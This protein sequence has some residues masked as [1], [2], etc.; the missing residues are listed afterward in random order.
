LSNATIFISYRRDD[1]SG[2]A[3]RLYDRLSARFGA[4]RIFMDIDTIKPGVDFVTVIDDAVAS[5]AVLIALIGKQWLT[6]TDATGARRLDNPHDFNRLEIESG[7]KRSTTVIPVLVEGA[8]MPSTEDLPSTMAALAR[9]NAIELSDVRWDYDVQR[10]ITTI[11]EVV[12]EPAPPPAGP[13]RKKPP[14]L[15]LA[16][17]ALVLVVAVVAAF[18]LTQGGSPACGGEGAGTASLANSQ[19]AFLSDRDGNVEIYGMRADGTRVARFTNDPVEELRADWSPD[20]KQLVFGAGSGDHAICVKNVDGSAAHVLTSAAGNE[21]APEWSPDGTKIAFSAGSK[22]DSDIFIMN[23]DGSGGSTDLTPDDHHRNRS[24]DWSSN[25]V[26]AFSSNLKGTFD[27]FTM[28]ADGTGVP[29][30][31]TKGPA[32]DGA[33]AWSSHG[34]R[35]VFPRKEHGES[36]L[37]IMNADGSDLKL[38]GIDSAGFDTSPAW[39]PDDQAIAFARRGESG[40]FDI[41]RVNVESGSLQ[42]LTSGA[43]GNLD[44]AW[45]PLP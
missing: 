31:L 16:A 44:P 17:G 43:G 6:I 35:I 37:F 45:G 3:G 19:I 4:E 24:P 27:I 26:I 28:P 40:G 38:L 22:S 10:L 1:T 14:L 29:T 9:R 23:A 21:E 15:W 8:S 5:C 2:H 32:S 25:N 30:R 12:G 39:S 36:H 13:S 42:Q 33:P 11:E 7:L 34:S 41:F 18:L 20:G